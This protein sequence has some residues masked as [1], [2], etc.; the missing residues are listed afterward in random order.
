FLMEMKRVI[1]A[2]GIS[3]EALAIMDNKALSLKEIAF[4]ESESRDETMAIGEG[5]ASRLKAF[6]VVLLIGCLGAGKTEFARGVVSFFGAGRDVCSPSYKIINRYEGK[7][8]VY[9]MDF[10]R[11]KERGE[12]FD[13][14]LE[15]IFAEKAIFIVEWPELG[16]DFFKKFY[17]AELKPVSENRREIRLFESVE[18]K[19]FQDE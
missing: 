13:I 10:Y 12:I 7:T 15:E 18:V 19:P 11:I 1:K 5:L 17:L 8:P 9:H 6:D 3:S 2:S 16:I 4:F 14:G